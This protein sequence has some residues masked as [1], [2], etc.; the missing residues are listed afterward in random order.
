MP[1][2]ELRRD[3]HFST[4]INAYS[5]GFNVLFGLCV[6]STVL[7]MLSLRGVSVQGLGDGTYSKQT[8]PD[9]E[10]EDTEVE[11]EPVRRG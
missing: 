5:T 2:C 10:Q 7:I 1:G 4:V 11:M 3:A 8:G 6:L 9:K